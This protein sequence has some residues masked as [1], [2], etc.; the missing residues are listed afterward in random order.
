VRNGCKVV[1]LM[2][3]IDY[4]SLVASFE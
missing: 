4:L 1:N 3:F 2:E